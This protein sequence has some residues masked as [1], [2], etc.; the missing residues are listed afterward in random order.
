MWS[1]KGVAR[2]M[3]K[4]QGKLR[5]YTIADVA[6]IARAVKEETD[7]LLA[8][9]S[10]LEN[11]TIKKVAQSNAY[12]ASQ[13]LNLC[14]DTA[15]HRGFYYTVF[16]MSPND[17]IVYLLDRMEPYRPNSKTENNAIPWSRE[18][19]RRVNLCLTMP[20]PTKRRWIRQRIS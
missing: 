12:H 15:G 5:K 17:S 3:C 7:L 6:T 9:A 10:A 13:T 16:G 2:A 4:V 8:R 20:R 14:E 11:D 1:S 19:R 18:D